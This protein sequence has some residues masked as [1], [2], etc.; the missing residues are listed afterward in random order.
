MQ[1]RVYLLNNQF[2]LR[3]TYFIKSMGMDDDHIPHVALLVQFPLPQPLVV[4][5]GV[6]FIGICT[7]FFSFLIFYFFKQS[8]YV[9]QL[10]MNSAFGNGAD[11]INA[12]EMKALDEKRKVVQFVGLLFFYLRLV[13]AVFLSK[14]LLT[15]LWTTER[16]T[17]NVLFVWETFNLETQ[18]DFCLACIL[19]ICSV[20]IV[21]F[22]IFIFFV[23]HITF[24]QLFKIGFFV[25]SRAHLAW[26]QQIPHYFQHL[27]ILQAV[28]VHLIYRLF[29][30]LHQL[31]QQ[32]QINPLELRR[33][34]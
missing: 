15:F 34:F 10:Y 32:Q 20:L 21:S 11:D 6:D 18:F 12:A 1:V 22:C 25:H 13:F 19:T 2:C 4:L 8:S 29:Q 5:K 27:L 14:S 24:L 17:L 16:A 7:R 30:L 9:N 26:N 33:R 28:Q 23:I 31:K 3:I